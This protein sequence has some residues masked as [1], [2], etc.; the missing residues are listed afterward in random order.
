M[1]S[2]IYSLV[3]QIFEDLC[4]GHYMKLF[5]SFLLLLQETTQR[6]NQRATSKCD[7]VRK[8]TGC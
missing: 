1:G 8:N 2:I 6:R 5:L 4:V 7:G 3:G